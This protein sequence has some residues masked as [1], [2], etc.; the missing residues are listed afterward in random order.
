MGLIKEP[1]EVDFTTIS[2]VWSAEEEKEFSDLIKKQ[3]EI[4]NKKQT[5]HFSSSFSNEGKNRLVV[6]E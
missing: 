5:I 1:V 4:R 3:K 6:Q 2:K